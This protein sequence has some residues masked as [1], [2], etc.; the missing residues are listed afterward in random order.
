MKVAFIGAG[1]TV[2]AKTLIGDLLSFPE[3]ADDLTLALMDI[4]GERLRTSEVVARRL[5]GAGVRVDATRDR[6]AALDG[7]DYVLTMIQVGGYRPATV[8]DFD[9]P[10]GFGLRQTI[11]D[12]IGIGGIMRGLRTVPVL[13]DICRDMEELCPDAWLLHTSIR[14]RSRAGRLRARA[15]S[16]A[17]CIP[18]CAACSRR[19]GFRTGTA[20]ATSCSS[21]SAISAPSR[22]SIS[23]NTSRGS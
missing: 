11:G 16:D 4:D 17:T 5:A 6:R 18:S 19:G 12:T 23:P 2:F 22:P 9:A 8:V 3:L 14:W 15:R 21:T 13:L 10:K 1:S 7:A 20:C